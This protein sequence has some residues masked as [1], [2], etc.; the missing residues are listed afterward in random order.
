MP[1]EIRLMK[2]TSEKKAD[3]KSANSYHPAGEDQRYEV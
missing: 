2:L 1:F 3:Q